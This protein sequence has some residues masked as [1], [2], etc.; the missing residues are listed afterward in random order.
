MARRKLGDAMTHSGSPAI[1]KLKTGKEV[2]AWLVKASPS[3]YDVA[4]RLQEFGGVFGWTLHDSY[5][6]DLM[7]I[8]NP[9]VLWVSEGH[10]TLESGVWGV[11]EVTR[12]PYPT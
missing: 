5:R 12:R 10:P 11:G 6:I 2:G 3:V 4:P 1:A 8:G 7:T 9:I